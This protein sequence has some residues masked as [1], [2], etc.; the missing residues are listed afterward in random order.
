MRWAFALCLLALA[1]CGSDVATARTAE[2]SRTGNE[3]RELAQQARIENEGA[4][5][6]IRISTTPEEQAVLIREDDAAVAL[7]RQVLGRKS[8]QQCMEL[9][10]VEVFI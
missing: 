8:M 5:E 7:L 2:A 4:I 3:Y 9:N 10:N 1:A 6:C